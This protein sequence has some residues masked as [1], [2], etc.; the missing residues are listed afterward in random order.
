MI[1]WIFIALFLVV[2]IVIAPRF[3]HSIQFYIVLFTI[4]LMMALYFFW[5]RENSRDT[6]QMLIPASEIELTDLAFSF[7]RKFSGQITNSSTDY[8][9]TE[10]A[11]E[12]VIE[13]C[14]QSDCTFSSK[15]SMRI[16]KEVA[17]G[18]TVTFN[19]YLKLDKLEKPKG[20]FQWKAEI[21]YTKAK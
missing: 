10:L 4:I 17:P 2:V 8:T 19:Q 15:G 7:N 5:Q 1:A 18:Q 20:Q 3:K 12:V 11:L 16:W 14:V 21:A 9:L 13:D 6:A